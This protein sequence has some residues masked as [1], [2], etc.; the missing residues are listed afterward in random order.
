MADSSITI[1]KL[2]EHTG[3]EMRKGGYAE[4]T[5]ATYEK[6][7][8]MFL[9]YAHQNGIEHY[10]SEF[11]HKFLQERFGSLDALPRNYTQA[12]Y[13]RGVCR[14]DD[15]Y[16]HGMI[17]S[18]R[19]LCKRN[20][21]YPPEYCDIV[22]V[23]LERRKN[24]GLSRSRASSYA[25]YLERFTMHLQVTGIKSF[26]HLTAK[27][28]QSFVEECAET[29]TA[30]TVSGTISCLRVFLA[31]LNEIGETA[32][33][34]GCFLPKVRYASEDA[35]PSAFTADEV[36][37]VLSC[38]DRCNPK[39]KRD[40]AMLMLAARLGMRAS[41]IIGMVFQNL[42]WESSMIEFEQ[43][44]TGKSTSLP[45]L[46]DVG[47]AIIDY[48]KIRPQT[49]SKQVFLRMDPPFLPLANCSLYE[50]TSNYMKR[51]EIHIPPGKKHGPHSLR[52]SLSSLLLENSVPLPIISG[53]LSH[54]S[55]DTTKVYLKID[56]RQLRECALPVPVIGAVGV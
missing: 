42:K 22:Q 1:K 46:N 24:A 40:Y 44:K 19:P 36:N 17:S 31:Y 55:S 54:S 2:T 41:D 32:L 28:V 14:L 16:V 8:R 11:A 7:W 26:G 29:Y 39:G 48:L 35:I 51:S 30:S 38:I 25:L 12:E 18:K 37:K 10:S 27:I 34:L 56:I 15:F 5:I 3:G 21:S 52:H 49:D 43:Q 50:I 45:L 6:I 23:Y 47:D 13:Y 33:D 9:A 20:Y 53:I 4:A